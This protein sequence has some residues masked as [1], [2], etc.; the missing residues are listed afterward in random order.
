MCVGTRTNM[1]VVQHCE[2][3]GG[4]SNQRIRRQT[5]PIWLAYLTYTYWIQLCKSVKISLGVLGTQMRQ[6]QY[7]MSKWWLEPCY[8][9]I[10][11]HGRSGLITS[12]WN[13]PKWG[14]SVLAESVEGCFMLPLLSFAKRAKPPTPL[15]LIRSWTDGIG[16]APKVWHWHNVGGDETALC[17]CS[18]TFTKCK[19]FHPSLLR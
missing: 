11:I 3:H 8:C 18:T 10:T 16:C 4:N 19:T 14:G 6:G 9:F 2:Q 17:P 1:S 13:L 15:S 7:V 12:M 5:K